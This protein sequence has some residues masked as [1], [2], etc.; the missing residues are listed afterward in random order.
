VLRAA[1]S[2]ALILAGSQLSWRGLG[3]LIAAR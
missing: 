2:L 3:A 1:I